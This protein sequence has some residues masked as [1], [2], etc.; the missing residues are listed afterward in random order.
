[1]EK[2]KG[3]KGKKYKPGKEFID[4]DKVK[5]IKLNKGRK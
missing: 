1:M 5:E 3:N 2:V 4:L